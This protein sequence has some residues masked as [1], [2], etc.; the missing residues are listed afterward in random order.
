MPFGP[1]FTFTTSRTERLISLIFP[2]ILRTIGPIF[3]TPPPGFSFPDDAPAGPEAALQETYE[4]EAAIQ[5]AYNESRDCKNA[6]NNN[7]S[8]HFITA[9]SPLSYVSLPHGL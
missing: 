1:G 5:E 4:F 7:S 2:Y 8:V 9:V 3:V 6:D